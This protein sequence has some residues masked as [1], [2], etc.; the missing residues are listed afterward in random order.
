MEI[1]RAARKHGIPE[2]DLRH[3]VD[4]ALYAGVLEGDPPLRVLYLGPDRAGNLLEV[5]VIERDDNSELAIHAMK[6]R[7]R[8]RDLLEG[9][10]RGE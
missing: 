3:A 5:V 8:Y 4:H 10:I 9:V 6:M 1:H 2:A 7:R